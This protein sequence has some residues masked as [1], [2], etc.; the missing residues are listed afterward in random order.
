VYTGSNSER[1]RSD[2]V[3]KYTHLIFAFLLFSLFNFILNFPVYISVFAFI[4]AMVPDLDIK[5]RS[6][7]RKIFHNV[8]FLFI[9]LFVLLQSGVIDNM[10]AAVF[11]IGFIS[12]L[13]TDSLTPTGIM[14]FWPIEKPRFRG[15]IKTGSSFEFL[16]MI[17]MLVFIFVF[18]SVLL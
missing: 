4:G 6:L 10:V 17:A 9:I 11:S 15:K 18:S 14:P 7:H 8:W 12:H 16:F 1:K 13:I 3:Q 5:V 2:Q